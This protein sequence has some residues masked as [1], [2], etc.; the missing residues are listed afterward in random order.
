MKIISLFKEKKV[1]EEITHTHELQSKLHSR[2]LRKKFLLTIARH[3]NGDA[4]LQTAI[5]ATVSINPEYGALL[6]FRARPI[7]NF[8]LDRTTKKSLQTQQQRIMFG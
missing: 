7:L 1:F 2:N 4:L 8:L 6:V 3:A 5:L